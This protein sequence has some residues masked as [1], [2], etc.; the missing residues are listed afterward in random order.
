MLNL[1]NLVK[2][3]DFLNRFPSTYVD[4][5]NL[6]AQRIEIDRHTASAS[7]NIGDWRED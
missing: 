6:D 3:K 1:P 2:L 4:L 7:E 5:E